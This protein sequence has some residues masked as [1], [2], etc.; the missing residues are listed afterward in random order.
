MYW[1]YSKE[2]LKYT[3]ICFATLGQTWFLWTMLLLLFINYEYS[4][5]SKLNIY[6][7]AYIHIHHLW[8]WI[9]R[10]Y[11]KIVI[12]TLL[13]LLLVLKGKNT[14]SLALVQFK[15]FVLLVWQQLDFLNFILTRDCKLGL[16]PFTIFSSLLIYVFFFDW[17]YDWA[18]TVMWAMTVY[19]NDVHD[20]KAIGGQKRLFKKM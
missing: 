16:V 5:M 11:L 15:C 12:L 18:V 4:K 14:R 1:Y 3:V 13:L 20:T 9:L 7:F 10:R 2:S 6:V 17:I 8:I 19:H